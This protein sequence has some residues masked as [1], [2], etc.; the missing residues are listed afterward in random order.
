VAVEG[1]PDLDVGAEYRAV[2]EGYF[3]TLSIPLLAG[4][5]FDSGDTA[6]GQRVVVVSRAAAESFW[7]GEDPL[8]RRLSATSMEAPEGSPWLTVVGVAE[9]V[10][11]FGF[12]SDIH[13]AMYVLFRQVPRTA[14]KMAL[15]VRGAGG[16]EAGLM[17]L[18]REQI[19]AVDDGLAAEIDTLDNRFAGGVAGQRTTVSVLG[20]F[21]ALAL[22]LAA[23]GIYALQ[24]FAVAQRTQ[25]IA[26]R[27]ALG[28]S[29]AVVVRGV[30]GGAARIAVAGTAAGLLAAWWLTG[31]LEAF[32][33]DVSPRDPWTFVAV[34]ATLLATA[35][36]AAVLPAWRAARLDPLQALRRT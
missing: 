12:D 29:Q 4:R 30:V 16:A 6:A 32:L 22:L 35:T 5:A 31:L 3:E 33:V 27:T 20:S 24:S 21:A 13:E 19:R 18:V 2:S 36:A 7:P 15:L 26:V 34:A 25:E 14:G 23:I 10:R 28:A 8:G 11:N 1:R 17:G 9:D